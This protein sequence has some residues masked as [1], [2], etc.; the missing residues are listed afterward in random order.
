MTTLKT[1]TMTSALLLGGVSLAIAQGPPT[2]GYPPVGGGAGGNPATNPVTPGPPG[3]GVI[4]G[5]PAS[6]AATSPTRTRIAHQPT[7]HHNKMYMSINRTHKGSKMNQWAVLNPVGDPGLHDVGR[8]PPLIL[9]DGRRS[10][11]LKAR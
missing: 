9:G 11:E 5:A 3:P 2:G 4:P 1:L 6:Q 8:D 10:L 7:K